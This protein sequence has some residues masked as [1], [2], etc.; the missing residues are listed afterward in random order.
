MLMASAEADGAVPADLEARCEAVRQ[1]ISKLWELNRRLEKSFEHLSTA[2]CHGQKIGQ[3][4]SDEFRELEALNRRAN[5]AKHEGLGGPGS[6]GP[7]ALQVARSNGD[8]PIDAQELGNRI[9]EL[10]RSY[11][12]Y[13][14]RPLRKNEPRYR[15]QN[16][17][18]N[19]GDFV[20]IACLDALGE[21]GM[22][23]VGDSYR[24]KQHAKHSAA[25]QAVNYL[26]V[27]SQARNAVVAG[28][29]AAA[30]AG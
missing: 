4:S 3:I 14:G 9:S 7:T 17:P 21:D 12:L 18:G 25:L 23:F 16:R 6:Q 2:M 8:E 26:G 27:L 11:A 29:D 30:V 1:Q 22:E 19:M 20:A 10:E 15:F 24:L 5:A 13:I 28:A